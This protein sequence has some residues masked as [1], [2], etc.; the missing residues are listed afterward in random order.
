MIKEQENTLLKFEDNIE[1]VIRNFLDEYFNSD[2]KLIE[3]N[4]LYNIIN[5]NTNHL[6]IK[7]ITLKS[8]AKTLVYSIIINKNTYINTLIKLDKQYAKYYSEFLIT[9]ACYTHSYS[10]DYLLKM[11][12]LKTLAIATRSRIGNYINLILA[13]SAK[14]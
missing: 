7:D 13:P 3:L 6:V 12:E 2:Y 9:K 5:K 1:N 10:V 11:K 14:F 8:V 4:G